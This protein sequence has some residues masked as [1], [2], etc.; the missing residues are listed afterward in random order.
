MLHSII[1][2]NCLLGR[3]EILLLCPED[4]CGIFGCISEDAADKVLEGLKIG[5][6]R[7]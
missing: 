1:V 4:M 7:V 6:S 3:L 5:V 2:N